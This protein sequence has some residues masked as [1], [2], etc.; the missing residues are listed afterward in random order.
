MSYSA[1][2]ELITDA[3][4]SV[5]FGWVDDGVYYTRSRGCVSARLG[6]VFAARLRVAVQSV[7]SL[8]YFGDARAVESHDVLARSAFLSVV[9]EHRHKFESITLLSWSGADT[10]QS[11]ITNL[12]DN[13]LVLEDPIE[14]EAR[15]MAATPRVRQK[16]LTKPNLDKQRLRWP[17]TR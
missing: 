12:G 1:P 8:R 7:T 2:L 16:A 4:G 10:S 17:L 6:E 11:F 9:V 3:A 5:T 15:L 13:A 14:F